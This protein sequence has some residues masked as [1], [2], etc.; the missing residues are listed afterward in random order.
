MSDNLKTQIDLWQSSSIS[1]FDLLETTI[2]EVSQQ[3]QLQ[4]EWEENIGI[5]TT[6]VATPHRHHTPEKVA[7]QFNPKLDPTVLSLDIQNLTLRLE[8]FSFRVEKGEPLTIFDPV[9]EGRGSITVKNV[10]I[11][12]KLEV[13]KERMF[14]NHLEAARPV[15]QLAKFDIVMEKLKLVFMDTGADWLLNGVLKGFR[16]QITEVVQKHLHDQIVSQV[17]LI[18]DTVN[19]FLDGNPDFLIDTLGIGLKD[20]DEVIVSV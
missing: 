14:R 15:L 19:S 8:E 6:T 12:L 3:I 11:A 17:H 5:N 4:K 20:L 9:F 7:K 10:S 16:Y 13:K 1:D 2:R 18:L